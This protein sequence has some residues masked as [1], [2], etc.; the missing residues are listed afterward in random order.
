MQEENILIQAGLSGEQAQAYQALLE[1]GPQ[2][3]SDLSKWTGIKRGLIY[4][5]LEQL[6]SMSLVSKKGGTGTVAVFSP[7]HPSLL[8]SNIERK[9]KE[10]ALTKEML[11]SSIGSLSSKYNLIT[12]KPNVQFFEGE[13]AIEKITGDYPENETE[14]RQWIDIN[15]ANKEIQEKFK[16][17]LEKRIKKGISKRMILPNNQKSEEYAKNAIEMTKIRIEKNIQNL[18][19]AVQV[20]DNK[21]TILTLEENKKIGL[22]IEDSSIALTLKNIFD[23]GWEKLTS[24][25][26]E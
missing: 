8:L 16:E 26:K 11:T 18:P 2:R 5:V 12:G 24:L 10:V 17:Y 13:D 6:E 25:E 1:K 19:T 15:L 20:Y 14:I 7:S 4:K 9:E 3:A 23:S 22:I 21:V